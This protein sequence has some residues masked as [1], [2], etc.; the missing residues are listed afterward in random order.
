MNCRKPQFSA[1]SN[2]SDSIFSGLPKAAVIKHRRQILVAMS[3]SDIAGIT[4]SDVVYTYLPLYHAIGLQLAMGTTIFAGATNVVRKKFSA[5]N[6]WRDCGRH[7]V[8]VRKSCIPID[9]GK[10]SNAA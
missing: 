10:F 9:I 3:L 1:V 5:S 2:K 8:T 6:F 4:S 7:G